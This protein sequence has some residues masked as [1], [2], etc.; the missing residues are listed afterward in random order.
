MKPPDPIHLGGVQAGLEIVAA[1]VGL[2]SWGVAGAFILAVSM[3]ITTEALCQAYEL[4]YVAHGY[5][6]DD[7][8][9]R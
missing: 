6:Q 7:D 1:C 2:S 9:N 5:H 8:Q 4:W 3:F